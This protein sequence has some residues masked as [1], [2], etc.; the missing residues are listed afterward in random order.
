MVVGRVLGGRV[1]RTISPFPLLFGST[2]LGLGGVFLFWGSSSPPLVVSGLLITGLGI[3]MLF[4]M[5]LSLAIGT[6]PDCADLA[7]ARISIAAGSS[8]VV[9]PLTLGAVADEVGIRGAFGLVP[10]LLVFVVVF[11]ALG[12]R[13]DM[14]RQSSLSPSS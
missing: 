6:A 11:A 3:S 2:A 7:A 1:A 14:A 9:A 5:L 8:V 13:A 12:R 10:A 4:P